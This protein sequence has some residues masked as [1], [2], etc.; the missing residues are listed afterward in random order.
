VPL[1]IV[2][3]N[4]LSPRQLRPNEGVYSHID[5]AP[6]LVDLL[7]LSVNQHA[8]Q[9]QSMLK[10]QT[11]PQLLVQPFGGRHFQSVRYP[12]KYRKHISM[13]REFVYNLSKDPLETTSIINDIDPSLLDQFRD[14]IKTLLENQILLETNRIYPNTQSK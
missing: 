6:T 11:K 7:G 8:L 14:D 3:P 2:W 13:N 12:Y 1:L 5:V 9:G 4:K 10:K